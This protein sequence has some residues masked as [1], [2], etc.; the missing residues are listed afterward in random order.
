LEAVSRASGSPF[1]PGTTR[2]QTDISHLEARV[3]LRV[4]DIHAEHHRTVR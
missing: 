3:H 2:D 1:S 4:G